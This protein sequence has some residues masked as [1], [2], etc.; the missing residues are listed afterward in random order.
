MQKIFVQFQFFSLMIRLRVL[1]Q[2][3]LPEATEN[4]YT[5]PSWIRR[6]EVFKESEI[7]SL[8]ERQ[9]GG[10]EAG[11]MKTRWLLS[12]SE[13]HPEL[14]LSLFPSLALSFHAH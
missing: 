12:S 7:Q 14:T 1:N 9:E 4:F 11:R 5:F 6:T 8:P 10:G 2:L 3:A 13:V